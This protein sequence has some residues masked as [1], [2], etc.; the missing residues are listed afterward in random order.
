MRK[1]R[2]FYMVVA[3]QYKEIVRTIVA[4]FVLGLRVYL[5]LVY[6]CVF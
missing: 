3:M 1:V 4:L 2:I 6:F 5:C